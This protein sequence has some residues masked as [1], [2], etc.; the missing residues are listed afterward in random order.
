MYTQRDYQA[1]INASTEWPKFNSPANFKAVLELLLAEQWLPSR[2]TVLRAIRQLKLHR[3][4]GGSRERDDKKEYEAAAANLEKVLVEA[5]AP[6][7]SP[8]E[9]AEFASLRREDLE[10]R[11]WDDF[12]SIFSVRYAKACKEFGFIL[13]AKPSA[14]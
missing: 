9:L 8:P 10:H 6:P 1:A 14:T 3:T 13:P 7:L 4:D 11:Y 12:P 5:E 2:V